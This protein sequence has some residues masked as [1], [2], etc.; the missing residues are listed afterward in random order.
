MTFNEGKYRK[1]NW[2]KVFGERQIVRNVVEMLTEIN[3][4][5]WKHKRTDVTKV[6]QNYKND[7]IKKLLKNGYVIIMKKILIFIFKMRHGDFVEQLIVYQ[8]EMNLKHI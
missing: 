3:D 7:F 4:D 6:S 5:T 2:G 8:L 1:F